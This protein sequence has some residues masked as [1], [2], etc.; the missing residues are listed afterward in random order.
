MKKIYISIFALLIALALLGAGCGNK[1][2]KNNSQNKLQTRIPQNNES[3]WDNDN[4]SNASSTDLKVNTKIFVMGEKNIDGSITAEG[5]IIGASQTDFQNIMRTGIQR[6][7]STPQNAGTQ[8]QGS[9]TQ[10][11]G[12]RPNRSQFQNISQEERQKLMEERMKERVISMPTEQTGRT[13]EARGGTEGARSG[14]RVV[15]GGSGSRMNGEILKMDNNII[16]LKLTDGG[17]SIIFTSSET[18]IK[19]VKTPPSGTSDS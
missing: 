7:S 15:R 14:M 19:K 6:S 8:I 11:Q 18:I 1:D 12:Q 13:S 16:T 17:S 9:D 10:V 5:I 4:F 3:F 2:A